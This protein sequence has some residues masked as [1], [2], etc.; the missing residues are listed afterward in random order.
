MKTK[1]INAHEFVFG[2]N[3]TDHMLSVDWNKDGGWKRPQIIPYGPLK[4][5]VSASSLQY[6]ISCFEGLNVVKNRE[7]KMFQPFR[8]DK[9]MG[10][11]LESS[12]HI[13]LPLFDPA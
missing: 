6:G 5:P 8:V 13:D 11:L 12:S 9:H 10:H 7:S 2:K 3:F 4:I 1:P